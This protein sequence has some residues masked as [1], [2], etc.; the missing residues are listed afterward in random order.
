MG[1][2]SQ[3]KLL[4]SMICKARVIDKVA[5]MTSVDLSRDHSST[6]SADSSTFIAASRFTLSKTC[7]ITPFECMY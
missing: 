1:I 5:F 2:V 3:C 7:M 6:I 4:K